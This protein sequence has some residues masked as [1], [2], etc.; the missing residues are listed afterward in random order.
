M[1]PNPSMHMLFYSRLIMDLVMELIPDTIR[2]Y[3]EEYRT[4]SDF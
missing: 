2:T 4:K 3:L 1:E